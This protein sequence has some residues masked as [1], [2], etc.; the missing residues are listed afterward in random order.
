MK[1]LTRLF[2]LGVFCLPLIGCGGDEY[3]VERQYWY[4]KHRAGRIFNNPQASPPKQ[5]EQSVREFRGFAAK[6]KGTSR[7]VDA[8]FNIARIYMATQDYEKARVVLKEV[9]LG[10]KDSG[11]V[12]SEAMFLI[13]NS[14][15]MEDKWDLALA[16]YKKIMQAYPLT[17]RGLDIPVY[18]ALHYRIKHQPD[19]MLSAY[20]EAAG[21]YKALAAKDPDSALAL[22]AYNL[23]AKC[24]IEQ[25]QWKEA[26]DTYN[27]IIERFKGKANLASVIFNAALIYRNQLN[28]PAK[29][30]QCLQLLVNDYPKSRLVKPAKEFLK[31]LFDNE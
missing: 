23:A 24:Y 1:K 21:H 9:M 17:A 7:A 28:D 30:K 27:L 4:I 19:K 2:I 14:Y 25:R 18:I 11:L 12:R 6:H 31:K 3:S 13:G 5:V 8:E 22:N 10:Y 26:V 16:E 29:A 15:E 20:Q